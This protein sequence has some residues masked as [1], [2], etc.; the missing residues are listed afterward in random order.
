MNRV[1][2]DKIRH[3]STSRVA[4]FEKFFPP[5]VPIVRENQSS[6]RHDLQFSGSKLPD[7]FYRR[8]KGMG[9]EIWVPINIGGIFAN[10]RAR[11][12]N[13]RAGT[14]N[15]RTGTT[16]KRT[17]TTN[18]RAGIANKRVGTADKRTGT[19]DKRAGTA[20]KRAGIANKRARIANN[21][22]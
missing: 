16:N 8:K 19:A 21:S 7:F 15:K 17:G 12:A 18:K 4:F 3:R 20:N 5:M 11:I 10:K 14:A 9:I 22:V 2:F 6:L 1:L 13:K